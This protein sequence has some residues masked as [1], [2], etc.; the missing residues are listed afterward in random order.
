MNNTNLLDWDEA[1]RYRRDVSRSDSNATITGTAATA[2]LYFFLE[3]VRGQLL[4]SNTIGRRHRDKE[5]GKILKGGNG[6]QMNFNIKFKIFKKLWP[7][8]KY[9]RLSIP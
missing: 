8:E 6:R 1:C 3:K 9:L 5:R 2:A 7:E 4:G